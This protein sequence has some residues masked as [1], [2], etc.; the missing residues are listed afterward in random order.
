MKQLVDAIQTFQSD[1][2]H[3]SPIKIYGEGT[4]TYEVVWYYMAPKMNVGYVEKDIAQEHLREIRY[5]GITTIDMLYSN[6]KVNFM[7]H[8]S[9]LHFSRVQMPEIIKRYILLFI[10][11]TERTVIS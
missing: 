10:A 2:S 1:S 11:G 4:I 8:Q 9:S 7:V 3:N 5:N 6:G